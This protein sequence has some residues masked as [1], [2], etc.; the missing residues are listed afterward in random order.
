M[1]SVLIATALACASG[2]PQHGT[3]TLAPPGDR[4]VGSRRIDISV[5]EDGFDPKVVSVRKGEAVTFVFTRTTDH[6]C[7][8]EVVLYLS[9]ASKVKRTLPLGRPVELTVVFERG[10]ELGYTCGMWMR[11][12]VIE[13][14]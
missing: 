11:S 5:T 6:T 10:G 2:A 3:A 4:Q 8:K 14:R 9:D 1:P 7:A 12:G 13:I